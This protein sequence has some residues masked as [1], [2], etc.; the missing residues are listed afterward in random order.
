[1][2]EKRDGFR[3]RLALATMRLALTCIITLKRIREKTDSDWLENATVAANDALQTNV[4]SQ[5]PP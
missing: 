1:M 3:L 2:S 4:T 5:S